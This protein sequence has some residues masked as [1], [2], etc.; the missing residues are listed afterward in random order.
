MELCRVCFYLFSLLVTLL[1]IG[2]VW[3]SHFSFEIEVQLKA[4]LDEVFSVVSDPR[5]TE[6]FHPLV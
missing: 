3:E 1:T 2:F 6:N 4:S 5:F